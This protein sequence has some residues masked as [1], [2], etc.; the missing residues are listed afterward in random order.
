MMGD[1][2]GCARQGEQARKVFE[3]NYT[4]D[5]CVAQYAHVLRLADAERQGKPRA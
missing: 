2:Q 3:Q 5:A 4:I 1:P